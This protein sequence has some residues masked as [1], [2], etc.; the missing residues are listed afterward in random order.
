MDYLSYPKPCTYLK[1]LRFIGSSGNRALFFSS[2]C[3]KFSWYSARG[4]PRTEESRRREKYY[5]SNLAI[6]QY[7][8]SQ[9]LSHLRHELDFEELDGALDESNCYRRH[10]PRLEELR[11]REL[12][13][14]A[15][16][17][18]QMQHHARRAKRA[19]ALFGERDGARIR[20]AEGTDGVAWTRASESYATILRRILSRLEGLRESILQAMAKLPIAHKTL[21]PVIV[22]TRTIGLMQADA[23][24]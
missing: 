15:Y 23:P 7:S 14:T 18:Q 20:G 9:K 13:P 12:S 5:S 17:L 2:S 11:Y 22:G 6:L 1:L 4:G 21:F 8:H 24:R 16:K 3:G 19:R 10:V